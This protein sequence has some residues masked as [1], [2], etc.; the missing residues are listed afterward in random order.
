MKII[1]LMQLGPENSP[2]KSTLQVQQGPG[3]NA[4]EGGIEQELPH[5]MQQ[6]SCVY[7]MTVGSTP[8]NAAISQQIAVAFVGRAK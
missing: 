4:P 8:G 5:I 2:A 3:E 7:L 1:S 6:F